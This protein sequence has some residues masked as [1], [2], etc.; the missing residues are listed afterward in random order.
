MRSTSARASVVVST[1]SATMIGLWVIVC[2]AGSHWV[3]GRYERIASYETDRFRALGQHAADPVGC[4]QRT[5][6]LRCIGFRQRDQQAAGR[7]RVVE[8]IFDLRRDLACHFDAAGGELAII[9]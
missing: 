3:C 7:L 5:L 1:S 8:Q 9:L 2:S 4:R 6:E